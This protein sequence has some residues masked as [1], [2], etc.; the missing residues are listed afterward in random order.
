MEEYT[1]VEDQ[2]ILVLFYDYSQNDLDENLRNPNYIYNGQV[3]TGTPTLYHQYE[4]DVRLFNS[5]YENL[6][7]GYE[8]NQQPTRQ[9]FGYFSKYIIVNN[10]IATR[11]VCFRS[12]RSRRTFFEGPLIRYF[13]PINVC[14]EEVLWAIEH[15]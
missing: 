13:D 3:L 6:K 5:L 11:L 2:T 9:I 14:A 10:S 12:D 1:E 15:H 4:H 7:D 8:L